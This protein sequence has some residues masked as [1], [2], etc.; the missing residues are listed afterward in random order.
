M[1]FFRKIEIPS[2]RQKLIQNKYEV[3]LTGTGWHRIFIRFPFNDCRLKS[4]Q[5]VSALWCIQMECLL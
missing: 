3:A 4:S 2:R 5:R 1:S